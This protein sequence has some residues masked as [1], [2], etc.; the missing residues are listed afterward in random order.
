MDK[1]S[2]EIIV[3]KLKD[4]GLKEGD[5]VLVH[6]SFKNLGLIEG[7]DKND[8][9]RYFEL[10]LKAFNEVVNFDKGTLVVPTFSHEYARTNTPF[11]YEESPSEVGAFTEYI[12]KQKDSLRSIHPINSF[13]AIGKYKY[14]ICDNISKSCYG[15]NSIFD[16]LISLNAHM[17]FF[18]ASMY[19]MTLKHHMEHVLGLPYVYHKAYFTPVYKDSKKLS[20]PFLSCVRYLN[21]KVNNNDCS[22]FKKYLV[23]KQMLKQ[24]KIGNT[25]ILNMKIKDA[26]DE[27]VDLLTEDPTYFLEEPYYETN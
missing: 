11:I 25:E 7:I 23:S 8:R 1:L 20:L 2:Y 4:S 19:H 14:E 3:E 10:I 5:I 9:E 22:D 15:M 26:Y 18:G 12:R 16:R 21:G 13:C 17:M 27:A 6:S 24:V